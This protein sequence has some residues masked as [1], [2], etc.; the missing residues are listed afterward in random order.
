MAGMKFDAE[1]NTDSSRDRHAG[2]IRIG[3]GML[4]KFVVV[5]KPLRLL[6]VAGVGAAILV[7]HA[8]AREPADPIRLTYIEGDVAGSTKILS[9]DGAKTIGSVEYRQHRLGDRLNAVRVARFDD[10]SSDEDR[11]E[12]RV[13]KT[14]EALRGRSIIRDVHGTPVVD[15]TVDVASGHLTGFS[16]VGKERTTY[17]ERAALTA[18][19]Y[20]GPLVAIVVKNFDQNA[21]DGRLVFQ[22]LVL[23][24]APRMIDMELVR[25]EATALKRPGGRVDVVPLAMRPTINFIVDPILQWLTPETQF[26]VSPGTPPALVRFAGPRN[27]AGQKIR[28]E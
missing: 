24:P 14:L 9:P 22:T 1:L 19:T 20:W 5:A 2:H 8:S 21:S 26:F 16:L 11:A 4:S 28:I 7:G 27:Y 23:T 10:G 12:A 25:G 17:D 6:T 3:L 13:G 15:V 18:G